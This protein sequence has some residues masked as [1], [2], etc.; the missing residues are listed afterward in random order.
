MGLVVTINSLK[1]EKGGKEVFKVCPASVT[2]MKAYN[3]KNNK[4]IALTR[5]SKL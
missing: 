1:R 4:A 2:V 3:H 5:L